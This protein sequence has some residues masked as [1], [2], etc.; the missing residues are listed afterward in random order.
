MTWNYLKIAY[1]TLQRNRLVSFINIFGLGLSM[2][3]GMMELVIVQTELGYD[4]FHPYPN[5]TYRIT[6]GYDQKNGNRFKLAST[7]LPLRA[8][9]AKETGFVEAA[10]TIYPAFMGL[11]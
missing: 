11:L 4:R 8:S 9:V 10:V 1:R 5:R 7:P 6:S 3:V 2:S